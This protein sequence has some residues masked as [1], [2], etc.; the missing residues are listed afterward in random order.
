MK[1]LWEKSEYKLEPIVEAF[2][3]KGD[4]LM[5]QK[6]LKYDV[7]GSL[8]HAKMLFKIGIL[9]KEELEKIRKA[10]NEILDLDKTGKF[11]LEV[12]DED[13]HTKIENYITQKYGAV[14]QKIHT[15]R[16]RNDQVLTAVRLYSKESL[17]NIELELTN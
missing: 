10:L 6:L 16:S 11:N 14:G 7:Q 5:D 1:K 2:E 12:G 9:S 15:G 3:T 13:I 17:E 4:L 8:A